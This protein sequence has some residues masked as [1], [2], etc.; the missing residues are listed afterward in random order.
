MDVTKVLRK[1]EVSLLTTDSSDLCSM[2]PGS[3]NETPVFTEMIGKLRHAAESFLGH[4]IRAALVATP[5]LFGER[6]SSLRQAIENNGLIDMDRMVRDQPKAFRHP[7]AVEAARGF[8]L[9]KNYH[10]VSAC[11]EE[12]DEMP[13]AIVL[14]I[15]FTSNSLCVEASSMHSVYG[16]YPY[17]WNPADT[18]FTL[19]YDM[20]D[21]NPDERYYWEAVRDRIISGTMAAFPTHKIT[22]VHVFGD[23]NAVDDPRTRST[24]DA[25]MR[26]LLGNTIPIFADDPV[27]AVVKGAAEIAKR[28]TWP[29]MEQ[30]SRNEIGNLVV[31]V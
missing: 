20:R 23:S 11:Q 21:K 15:L 13:Y 2:F 19:G 8:G 10:N 6:T 5:L 27:F 31:Q 25:A 7:C 24:I 22:R 12:E 9:C 16:Y 1:S 29:Y 3:P 26:Q 17:A 30:P 18:D 28:G 4:K 14:S